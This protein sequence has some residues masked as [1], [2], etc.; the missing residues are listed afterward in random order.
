[1][2][3]PTIASTKWI[4]NLSVSRYV[5]LFFLLLIS[6]TMPTLINRMGATNIS[7]EP[8][9]IAL[10]SGFVV[11]VITYFGLRVA[12]RDELSIEHIS[13]TAIALGL[14]SAH[15]SVFHVS[16]SFP[17]VETYALFFFLFLYHLNE[18]ELK[19]IV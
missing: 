13:S 6:V 2:S 16:S 1:M 14:I 10:L 8:V 3:E 7:N 5:L 17:R 4:A 18:V 9:F 15:S 19:N 11:S 12:L